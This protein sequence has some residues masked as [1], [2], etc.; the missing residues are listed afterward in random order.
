M[1]KKQRAA[2]L[3][4]AAG[5]LI[6][7]LERFDARERDTIWQVANSVMIAATPPIQPID[8]ELANKYRFPFRIEDNG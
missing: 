2:E 1:D 3:L 6:E 8:P 4:Y 5:Q 7:Q